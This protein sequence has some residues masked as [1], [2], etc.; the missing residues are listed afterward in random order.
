MS[1]DWGEY[2]SLAEALCGVAVSGPL[3]SD[4][5]QYRSSV[6]RAYYAAF[7][8]ARNRLRDVDL[9]PI[10]RSVNAHVFVARAY[11]HHADPR[12]VQIGVRLR[13]LG[14]DRNRCDYDDA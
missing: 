10:P 2:L 8:L 5:A 12:R 1:F 3:I 7:I 6:S 14:A 13:D 9:V 4:E 11:E